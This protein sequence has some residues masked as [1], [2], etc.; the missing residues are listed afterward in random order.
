MPVK[1]AMENLGTI[2][3]QTVQSGSMKARLPGINYVR[4]AVDMAGG[5]QTV[6][7]Q[8]GVTRTAVYRWIER[9]TMAHV[10]AATVQKLSEISGIP[11]KK[12]I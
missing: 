2:A 12:L 10:P 3:N 8:L 4:V 5:V 11:L 7:K 9:E 1:R 6:A